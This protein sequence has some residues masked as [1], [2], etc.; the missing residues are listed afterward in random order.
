MVRKFPK[1]CGRCKDRSDC[2]H[3]LHNDPFKCKKRRPRLSFSELREVDKRVAERRLSD[4]KK[5]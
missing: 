1:G 3:L 4:S 2:Q 5:R